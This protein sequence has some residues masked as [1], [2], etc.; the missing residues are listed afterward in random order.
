MIR[1]LEEAAMNAWPAF[2]TRLYDGW[3]LRFAAGYTRRAN[4]INP[5]YSGSLDLVEKIEICE[6][7]YTRQGLATIFKL[8]ELDE[9]AGLDEMLAGRGYQYDAVTSVQTLDLTGLSGI[10]SPDVIFSPAARAPWRSAFNRM[11]AVDE[12]SQVVHAQILSLILPQ[13]AFVGMESGPG[14]MVSCGLGVLQNGYL[15]IFDLVTD[16]D[17]RRHGYAETLMHSLLA[18]GQKQGARTAYLQVMINNPPALALYAGLGFR[19]SYHY[20]YRVKT[21]PLS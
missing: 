3:V 10:S 1:V 18:W 2:Q 17:F 13:T 6:G 11:H 5:I 15:G 4:S 8:T 20:W 7:I 19:E 12:T 16:P 9:A 14:Q 21:L